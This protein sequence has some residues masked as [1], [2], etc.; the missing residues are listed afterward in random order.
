MTMAVVEAHGNC[1]PD[2]PIFIQNGGGE[3]F[4]GSSL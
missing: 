1:A 2:G 4:V 3:D